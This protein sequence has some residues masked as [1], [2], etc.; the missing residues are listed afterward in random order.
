MISGNKIII[1][2]FKD[3]D[4]VVEY[5]NSE[6]QLVERAVTD[7]TEIFPMC[8]RL[9]V[10]RETGF[11]GKDSGSMLIATKDGRPVGSIGFIR[12]TEF[13]LSIG[14]RISRAGDRNKGYMTEALKL[15]SSYLFKTVPFITRLML[16]TADDN[17]SSR[18]LAEKCGFTQEG[19]MR[20][21]YFYRGKICDWILYSILR[22]ECDDF[23]K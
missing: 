12:K 8:K 1:R 5:H 13:E 3:E 9:A 19:V 21:A 20:K 15:F 17:L 2:L 7:H 18:K 23:F 4:E 11:W 16:V 22:E 14:Y 6:N 10:F